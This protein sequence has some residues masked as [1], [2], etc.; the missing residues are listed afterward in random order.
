MAT[1]DVSGVH[2][3]KV[4]VSW[5]SDARETSDIKY[6]AV[7]VSSSGDNTIVAAVSGKY[8]RV[9]TWFLNANGTVN[10]RWKSGAG[11]NLTGLFYLLA[12]VGGVGPEA[13]R[14]HFQT[15]SNT[16]LVL[17]L[18]AGVAV[19]GYVAYVEETA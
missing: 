11:T 1:T 13:S 15:A 16:A 4:R 6:A 18:S 19:G 12:N 17:N 8:I 5:G 2:H 9:I 3:Q 7:D 10:A 14:G